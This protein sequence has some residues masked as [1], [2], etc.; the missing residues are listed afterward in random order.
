MAVSACILGESV[1]HYA[2]LVSKSQAHHPT[3]DKDLVKLLLQNGG[4]VNVPNKEYRMTCI[5]YCSKEG[6][7]DILHEILNQIDPTMLQ[8]AC[9]RIALVSLINMIHIVFPSSFI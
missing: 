8:G 6:N 1:L 4:E 5:H 3:E 2:S 7:A 9:N